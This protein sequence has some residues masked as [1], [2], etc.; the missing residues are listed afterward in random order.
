MHTQT[1]TLILGMMMAI[2]IAT[3]QFIFL[4]DY[5]F[6]SHNVTRQ[7]DPCRSAMILDR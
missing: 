4:T 3:N 6:A 2:V 1:T 7:M 5:V